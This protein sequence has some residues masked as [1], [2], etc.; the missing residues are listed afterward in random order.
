MFIVGEA[1]LSEGEWGQIGEPH[2]TLESATKA[3]EELNAHKSA[4]Q[5]EYYLYDE[6]GLMSSPIGMAA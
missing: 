4:P 3:A 5:F 2:P 1:D 6:H